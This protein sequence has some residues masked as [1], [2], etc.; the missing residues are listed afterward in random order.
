MDNAQKQPLF[1]TSGG[2]DSR[3]GLEN[4]QLVGT[5]LAEKYQITR[6]LGRG[7]TSHVYLAHEEARNRF[8]AVKVLL[9]PQAGNSELFSMFLQD[10]AAARAVSHPS[11]VSLDDYGKLESGLPYIVGDYLRDVSL[12]DLIAK[13]Q[14]SPKRSLAILVQ[15]CDALSHAHRCSVI[16]GDLKPSNVMV[17]TDGNGDSIRI[18]DF[19]MSR[20]NA[21]EEGS[22]DLG[23]PDLYASPERSSAGKFDARSDLYSLACIMYEVFMGTT[24]FVGTAYEVKQQHRKAVPPY[25][26]LPT[27]PV[28]VKRKLNEI[29]LRGMAK[30]PGFRYQT[31]D[32]LKTE[33]HAVQSQMSGGYFKRLG[34]M[35]QNA[36]VNRKD[37]R[38]K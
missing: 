5:L 7:P 6:V 4:A 19:G 36:T 16:H 20:L 3:G 2:S 31:A 12:A 26:E 27:V 15:L 25:M 23:P 33:L 1:D 28:G 35:I 37:H 34:R 38:R 18:V 10:A 17:V 21:C 22:S 29:V 8:V 32:E 14:L 24:P 30:S 11:I 9:S 13:G